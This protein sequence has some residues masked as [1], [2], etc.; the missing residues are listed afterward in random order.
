VDTLRPTN[1]NRR[2]S[3]LAGCVLIG[4]LVYS[5]IAAYFRPFTLAMNVSVALPVVAVLVGVGLSWR[6]TRAHTD[7]THERSRRI[8]GAVWI[9]LVTLLVT[10]ELVAY[11][12]SPRHDHPTLST[13]ADDIMSIHPGRALMFALWLTL[14]WAL[15]LRQLRPPEGPR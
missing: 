5:W 15:F 4:A 13:I 9:G 11:V 8:A 6:G 10:W 1:L 14:G 2:R 12:S 3:P 7:P